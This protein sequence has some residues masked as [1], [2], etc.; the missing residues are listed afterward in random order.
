M[1][2]LQEVFV[3]WQDLLSPFL[4]GLPVLPIPGPVMRGHPA[5]FSFVLPVR[6]QLVFLT[7]TTAI[8]FWG[9][10]LWETSA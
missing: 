5:D 1:A 6:S 3:P 7:S 2:D 9:E 4:P 10:R 8:R